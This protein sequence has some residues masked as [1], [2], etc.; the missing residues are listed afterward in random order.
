MASSWSNDSVSNTENNDNKILEFEILNSLKEFIGSE[1][2]G[3][4]LSEYINNTLSNIDRLGYAIA[5]EDE[6]RVKQ[7]SHKLKGSA[8]NIGAMKLSFVCTQMQSMALEESANDDLRNQF[9]EIQNI[10]QET[11]EALSDY[12]HQ[13][14]ESRLKVG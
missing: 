14:E 9:R 8:G 12:I 6:E 2:F 4:Y 7:F 5:S 11:K 1:P 10:Y 3:Q 13:L